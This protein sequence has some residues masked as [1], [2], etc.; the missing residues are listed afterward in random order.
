[1]STLAIIYDFE[2]PIQAAFK[3]LLT[4]AGLSAF[5]PDDTIDFQ[6][7]RPRVEILFTDSGANNSRHQICPDGKYRH[8]LYKGTVTLAVITNPRTENGEQTTTHQE[9]KAKVR[10]VMAEAYTA[11]LD[12]FEIRYVTPAGSTPK[13]S[14][15]DGVEVSNLVYNIDFN[16]KATSWPN[17]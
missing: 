4:E 8:D 12:D 5:T 15:E 13:I 11:E 17:P 1:M 2:T 6:K 16:I 3:A 14:P 9:Y 7:D 10:Q